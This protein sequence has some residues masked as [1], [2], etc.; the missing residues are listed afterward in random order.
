[1]EQAGK[2]WL[3]TNWLKSWAILRQLLLTAERHIF[4]RNICT[5]GD[6]CTYIYMQIILLVYL[7]NGKPYVNKRFLYYFKKIMGAIK[8]I[9]L[10][11]HF[12]AYV[13]FILHISFVL[14][15]MKK[16]LIMPHSW[17]CFVH[18]NFRVKLRL[19]NKLRGWNMLP[20]QL[21]L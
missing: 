15:G 2:H 7:V 16:A 10:L 13:S 14:N 21:T 12:H 5:S 19:K 4:Y 20:R 1:M 8:K 11:I 18:L 17:D 9:I 3:A 6:F